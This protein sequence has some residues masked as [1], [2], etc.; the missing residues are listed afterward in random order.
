MYLQ[1]AMAHKKRH[2][3]LAKWRLKRLFVLY[4]AIDPATFSEASRLN[5]FRVVP[6]GDVG[7]LLCRVYH[8]LRFFSKPH[9]RGGF[10]RVFMAAWFVANSI[11]VDLVYFKQVGADC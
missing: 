11:R 4:F 9:F 10:G 2:S 3:I 6:L 8:R 5:A 1:L 7:Q